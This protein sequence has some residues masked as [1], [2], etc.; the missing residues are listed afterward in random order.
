MGAGQVFR[1]P[2]R[3]VH[4]VRGDDSIKV[5]MQVLSIQFQSAEQDG[6]LSI[7]S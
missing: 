1:E 3:D 2:V 4:M 5:A 7:D 6:T